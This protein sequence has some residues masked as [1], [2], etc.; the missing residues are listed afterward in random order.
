MGSARTLYPA[1]LDLRGRRCV[2]VGGGPV[3][4]RKVRG[5]LSASARVAVVSPDLSPGLSEL[6]AAGRVQAILRGY[7]TGDLAR[8]NPG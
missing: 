8:F 4:E 5:L 7:R 1:F 2:V 3:G 6:A